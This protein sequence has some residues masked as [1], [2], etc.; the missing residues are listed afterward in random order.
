VSSRVFDI[1][2]FL[3]ALHDRGELD[4]DFQR[5]EVTLPYHAP[6]QLKSAGMGLPAVQLMELVP[7]VHVV[8]SGQP[9]C[10]IAGTYGLKKEKYEV[11][12]AVGRPVFDFIKETNPEWVRRNRARPS[13]VNPER[14]K[15]AKRALPRGG[16]AIC[17]ALAR[18]TRSRATRRGSSSS[19]S[20]SSAAAEMLAREPILSLA[21]GGEFGAHEVEAL[22]EGG[23]G[24][25]GSIA[26]G[27]SRSPAA[28]RLAKA[29]GGTGGGRGAPPSAP[30]PPGRLRRRWH[31]A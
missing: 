20:R 1:C 19:T 29:S 23:E 30:G 17:S 27:A 13:S 26:N 14:S 21:E 16:R 6:C 10:G 18:I 5:M 2:E 4:E 22:G 24:V 31:R 3:L 11:A 28:T 9:C 7:G 12:Q 25:A 8:E 15:P